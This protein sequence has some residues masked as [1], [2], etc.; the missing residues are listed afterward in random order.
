[1]NQNARLGTKTQIDLIYY[2]TEGQTLQAQREKTK[3]EGLKI[4]QI[5][6]RFSGIIRGTP[7]KNALEKLENITAKLNAVKR[8]LKDWKK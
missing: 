4:W 5:Q 2:R 8:I 6:S 1:M 7:E 3:A